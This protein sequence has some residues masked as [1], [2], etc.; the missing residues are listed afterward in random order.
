MEQI[1]VGNELSVFIAFLFVGIAKAFQDTCE[2]GVSVK[3]PRTW[4]KGQSW[5]NKYSTP[6]RE[7]TRGEWLYLWFFTPRYQEKFL[8]SS[9]WFVAGSDF[10]HIF[11]TL[12]I[13]FSLIGVITYTEVIVWY[14]DLGAMWLC[15]I[16]GFRLVYDYLKEG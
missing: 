10:W 9:S 12:R 1:T 13:L 11:N 15:Y 5:V 16:A 3:I 4:Y 14:V 8:Y 2:E 7:N 6:L